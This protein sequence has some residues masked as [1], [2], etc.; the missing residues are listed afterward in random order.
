MEKFCC[1]ERA[2]W[3]KFTKGRSW[4]NIDLQNDDAISTISYTDC[5]EFCKWLTKK[6]LKAKR[7]MPGWEYTL[8]TE[9][10]WEYSCRAGSYSSYAND[11]KLV[12]SG[13]FDKNSHF[14][15]H[16]P[17]LKKSNEWGFYDMHGNLWEF[18]IDKSTGNSFFDVKTETYIDGIIDR[19]KSIY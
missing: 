1:L 7:L 13:F 5:L 17:G 6:E 12:N 4:K 14:K 18:C 16:K 8:P 10:Q 2:S 9:A 19:S 3:I 15:A 11:L